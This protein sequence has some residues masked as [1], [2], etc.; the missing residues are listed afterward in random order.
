MPNREDFGWFK[1]QF[2]SKIEAA[3]QNTP[4]NVTACVLRRSNPLTN[5]KAV[6]IPFLIC[7]FKNL[8]Q[9]S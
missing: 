2:H 3:I 6:S 1:Q 4:L 7:S 5:E 9:G 8:I